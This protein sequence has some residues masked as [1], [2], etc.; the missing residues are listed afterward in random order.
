MPA[1]GAAP[2]PPAELPPV[3]WR[4]R[5]AAMTFLSCCFLSNAYTAAFTSYD[6]FYL[7]ERSGPCSSRR[8]VVPLPVRRA[9][10]VTSR[11]VATASAATHPV[12]RSR[13]LFRTHSALCDLFLTAPPCDQPVLATRSPD[14]HLGDDLVRTASA[15]RAFL[16]WL[17][18]R[19]A[20]ARLSDCCRPD[21]IIAVFICAWMPP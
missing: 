19:R 5:P 8:S 2:G 14:P 9:F 4:T 16:G 12:S 20:A 13:A 11:R 21:C 10:G 3:R 1:P 17:R 7:I 6:T 18:A 15:S